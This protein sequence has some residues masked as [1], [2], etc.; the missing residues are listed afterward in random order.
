MHPQIAWF[1]QA[2]INLPLLLVTVAL[3]IFALIAIVA[4]NRLMRGWLRSAEARVHLSYETALTL[5]RVVSG[6]LWLVTALLVLNL[7]GISVSGVWTLLASAI[8][9]IGVGFLAVWT[10][11]SNVTASFFISLWRPFR[12]GQTVEI[13]PEALKGRVIDRNL[14]FTIL[15][16]EGGN[17]LQVP[18]NLFFQ[19]MFRVSDHGKP[20]MFEC[21][22]NERTD[23]SG[24]STP[25][26][27]S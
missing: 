15:R 20:S 11:V 6:G 7:W 16:D 22:E 14:M 24:K 27:S 9:V 26:R 10:M 13:L 1:D 23:A 5:T 12:L 18:N 17:L 2:N 19:K 8:A 25:P 3:I 21:L 4:L